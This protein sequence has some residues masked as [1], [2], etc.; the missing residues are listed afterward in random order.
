M[1]LVSI[2]KKSYA[3]FTGVVLIAIAILGLFGSKIS[4]AALIFITLLIIVAGFFL[5]NL[6]GEKYSDNKSSEENIT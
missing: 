1:K 4:G 3:T 5:A 6:I 2:D